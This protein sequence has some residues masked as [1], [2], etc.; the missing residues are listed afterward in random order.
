MESKNHAADAA[1]EAWNELCST[2][3]VACTARN[4][5]FR[6][7][8]DF[9]LLIHQKEPRRALRLEYSPDFKKLRYNTGVTGWQQLQAIE[10]A[11]QAIVFETPYRRAYSV[12]ELCSHV[13]EQLE[14]SPF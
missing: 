6:R 1:L 8:E 9:V 11:Q 7:P 5:E 13:L 14:K 10:R 12:Q 4:L 3:K 2:L